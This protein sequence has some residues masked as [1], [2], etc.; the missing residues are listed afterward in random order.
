MEFLS[1]SGAMKQCFDK[2]VPVFFCIL[3]STSTCM[4]TLVTLYIHVDGF[5]L[6]HRSVKVQ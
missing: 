3:C 1:S 2:R 5:M 6:F 4:R